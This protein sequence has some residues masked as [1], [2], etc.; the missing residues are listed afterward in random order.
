MTAVP[1][2]FGKYYLT[3]K[4]ATGGMAE[5]YLAKLIGPSGFEKQLVIKQIL[6]EYSDHRQFVELFVA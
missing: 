3:E 1:S 4:I 2:S 6:P 5:I